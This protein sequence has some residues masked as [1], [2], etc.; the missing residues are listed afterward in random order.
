MLKN[1]NICSIIKHNY[2]G[3]MGELWEKKDGS[4]IQD[5]N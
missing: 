2:I 5:H 3:K 4:L 1:A